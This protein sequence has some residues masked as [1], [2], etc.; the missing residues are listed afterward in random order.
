MKRLKESMYNHCLPQGDHT[1]IYNHLT[2]TIG[3]IMNPLELTNIQRA[4]EQG[5]TPE[6]PL[7][8]SLAED[9]FFVDDACHEELAADVQYTARRY[10]SILSPIILASEQCNFRCSYCYEEFKRGNIS[11]DVINAFI[12]YIRKNLRN[13]TGVSMGWFGGEP[14]LAAKE[15]ERISTEVIDIC[16]QGRKPYTAHMTTNGYLLDAPMMERMLRCKVAHYQITLDGMS[17]NHNQTRT[18][19]GGGPTFERIIANLRGIRDQV[20]ARQLSIAI[21]TNITKPQLSRLEEY[22]SF[23]AAEFGNDP[24]FS[25]L[26]RLAG[27]WGGERV[28]GMKD[29][30]AESLDTV[31]TVLLNSGVKLSQ[32]DTF[33]LMGNPIC[34]A[35]DR[36]SFILGS[37][38]TIYKCTVR[39]DKEYNHLGHISENGDLVLDYDKL[40]QWL[41]QPVQKAEKCATCATWTLCRNRT[42][43]AR[44]FDEA[45][46]K[47]N[48][49]FEFSSLDAVL[50]LLDRSNSEYVKEYA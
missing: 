28:Q 22:G 1:L 4:L 47:A 2:N 11:D 37:D 14:L 12:K 35:A 31:Y 24:R 21:R 39:F 19:A 25:F 30:L 34:Y 48:C 9:G 23:M 27:D 13:Y 46:S 38:G 18:L 40:N 8:A 44:V 50:T 20:K 33:S 45:S 17:E 15:I 7:F 10:S 5:K 42:C 26:F 16:V 49:S 41:A 29:E 6:G 36:N 43:P 32:T 3:R